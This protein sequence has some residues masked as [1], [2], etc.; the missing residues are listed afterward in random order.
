MR[1]ME[2]E[3]VCPL[4]GKAMQPQ[5]KSLVSDGM[6]YH[7]PFAFLSCNIH[8]IF[9]WRGGRHELF[10]L[11]K[12]RSQAIKVEPMSQEVVQRY[13]KNGNARM[14]TLSDYRPA[15]MKCLY[16]RGGPRRDGTWNQH[17]GRLVWDYGRI[18]RCPW[19]GAEITVEKASHQTV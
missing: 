15:K 19:C 16:C 1:Q 11:D 9:A 12:R 7:F 13:G 17:Y 5:G 3:G 6:Y 18:V 2:L 8:G 14:P 10:D 4:C